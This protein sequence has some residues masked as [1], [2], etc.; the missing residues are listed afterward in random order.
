MEK[1]SSRTRFEVKKQFGHGLYARTRVPFAAIVCMSQASSI[2]QTPLRH[3]KRV[4]VLLGG[5][6]AMCFTLIAFPS[7]SGLANKEWEFA[8]IEKARFLFPFILPLEK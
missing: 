8:K 7:G 6:V 1:L 4:L 3:Q 5:I 2:K